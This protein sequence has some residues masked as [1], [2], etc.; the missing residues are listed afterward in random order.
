MDI[1]L[2]LFQIIILS[3]VQGLT[4][5]L[6]VSSSAHLILVPKFLSW[7]PQGLALDV[8]VHVGTLGAI[9]LYF[10][11]DVLNMLKNVPNFIRGK[12]DVYECKE[13]LLLVIGT[14]PAIILGYILSEIGMKKLYSLGVIG[15]TSVVYGV[16][17]YYID[18]KITANRNLLQMTRIDAFKVGIAQA[19][20]LI[21][22]TSRSGICM[23]MGRYLGFTRLDAAKF[24]FLL[25]IPAI[26]A[27]AS[28]T[29]YKVIQANQSEI[30]KDAALGIF[31]SLI[32][33]LISIHFMMRWLKKFN[34]TPFVLYRVGLGLFLLSLFFLT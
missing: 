26:I 21:P 10:W 11:R 19:L 24:S 2:P 29:S 16:L 3:L 9:I 33:G 28:L 1:L 32:A 4:E 15:T 18:K 22:G 31:F 34:F 25:S 6:P 23:T 14:I 12:W 8:A 7:P 5:F 27:A 20:A 30:F 13:I 17:L